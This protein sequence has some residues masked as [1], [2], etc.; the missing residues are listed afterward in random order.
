MN[1]RPET[2][3]INFIAGLQGF[4]LPGLDAQTG[5]L[6]PDPKYGTGLGVGHHAADMHAV[7]AGIVR[8]KP[9]QA[10][11]RTHGRGKWIGRRGFFDQQTS[12]PPA[13]AA[14]ASAPG[15]FD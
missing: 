2:Q 1:C 7:S 14:P 9:E 10:V 6:V 15:V 4:R 3:H 13:L 8:R 12:R 5:G 11:S